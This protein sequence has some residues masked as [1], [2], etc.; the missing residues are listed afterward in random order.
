MKILI[1][2]WKVIKNNLLKKSIYIELDISEE[3]LKKMEIPFGHRA[4]ILK[5]IKEFK[6]QRGKFL[7]LENSSEKIL[8]DSITNDKFDTIKHEIGCGI[9]SYNNLDKYN[10]NKDCVTE[11]NNI[12][13]YDEDEQSRLFRKA[14]EEFR[15][16]KNLD[17]KDKEKDNKNNKISI[18]REVD[19]EVNEVNFYF[20]KCY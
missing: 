19:E 4:K 6:I 3:K 1:K 16:G 15:K 14:V 20:I 17:E 2:F 13:I 18:I 8:R 7:N 10:Y 9:D 5:K 12:E 11:E